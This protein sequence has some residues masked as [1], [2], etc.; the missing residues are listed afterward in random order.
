MLLS[1]DISR[2]LSRILFAPCCFWLISERYLHKKYLPK[3]LFKCMFLFIWR[4]SIMICIVSV[5]GI[6]CSMLTVSI[7]P[8]SKY[9]SLN[10]MAD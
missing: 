8:C 10:M 6:F 2:A 1:K 3:S 4:G 5:T 7:F 9:L